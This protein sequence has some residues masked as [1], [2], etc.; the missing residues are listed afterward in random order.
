M[1]WMTARPPRRRVLPFNAAALG[2]ALLFL[3]AG[4]PGATQETQSRLLLAPMIHGIELCTPATGPPAPKDE[5]ELAAQCR[6]SG[7]SAASLVETTLSGIGP[8]VSANGQFEVGYT[9]PVPLLQLLVPDGSSWQVDR[10]AVER[11]ALTVQETNRPVVLHLFST[12]F[13]IGAPIEE[14]LSRD[15]ANM[16]TSTLGSMTRDRYYSI[17]VYPWT[18]AS[19]NN[20]I[21]RYRQMVIGQVLDSICRLPAS[22]RHKIRAVTLLGELHH[23]HADFQRGMGVGGPYI[24]SDYSEASIEGFREFLAKRFGD[25][26]ALNRVIGENYASF[27]EIEPPSKNI[28]VDRLQRFSEHIDSFAHGKLPLIGWAFD[29]AHKPSE[30][31]WIQIYRNG[32]LVARVP[33]RYGRQ[34]VLQAR[35]S[36]GT[37]DVGWRFDLDF[38]ALLPGIHRLDF[39]VEGADGRLANLGSRRVVVM[40]RDRPSPQIHPSAAVPAGSGATGIE[41]S[42]DHPQELTS[43]YYNPLVPLWH[44][45][46]GEQVVR[47]L[48]H[49]ERQVRSSCLADVPLYTHQIAPFVNPSW[50]TTKFAV[51]ASLKDSGGLQLGISLYGEATYGSSFLDWLGSTNRR[52]YGITEFHP[53]KAMSPDEVKETFDRHR[54]RGATFLSFFVDA[55]PPGVRDDSKRNIFAIDPG[56]PDFGSDRLH[57]AIRAVVNE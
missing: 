6:E 55:R 47:Y 2:A 20:D 14:R 34:D 50:D 24:I 52:S 15:P 38:T 54:R 28:R 25:I 35:P 48:N 56:N 37:A 5:T 32:A 13:G 53:L 51:D 19:T 29:P 23:F 31:P 10:R 41:G 16:S 39:L 9:M 33:A 7:R 49:F 27:A 44:E 1:S 17:N 21:T 40:D 18:F 11:L 36:F 12:H 4:C 26:G 45:F 8:T 43:L 42:I 57:A 30:S 46:R 22:D 3:L